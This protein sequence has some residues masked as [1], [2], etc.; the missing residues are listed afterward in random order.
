MI[1]IANV[2]G[3]SYDSRLLASPDRAPSL[4]QVQRRQETLFWERWASG[5]MVC[6][7]LKSSG[8]FFAAPAFPLFSPHCCGDTRL[9]KSQGGKPSFRNSSRSIEFNGGCEDQTQDTPFQIGS[10]PLSQVGYSLKYGEH[11]SQNSHP[12][13][14]HH[15]FPNAPLDPW[16]GEEK[17]QI[18]ICTQT[19]K[20]FYGSRLAF[21]FRVA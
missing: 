16:I 15:P 20:A 8:S 21:L 19:F 9:P 6:N 18:L 4:A 11:R 5:I 2:A 17:N 1:E 7:D 10:E 3:R 13:G 14:P 12:A